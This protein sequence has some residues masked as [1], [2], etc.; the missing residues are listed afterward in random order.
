[1]KKGILLLSLLLILF[2][3]CTHRSSYESSTIDSYDSV[4]MDFTFGDELIGFEM[5]T[6]DGQNLESISIDS[7]NKLI[8]YLSDRCSPCIEALKSLNRLGNVFLSDDFDY[9]ICW[10][11]AIPTNLLEKYEIEKSKNFSLRGKTRLNSIVPT[12]FLLNED[13]IVRFSTN[14]FEI[15]IEKLFSDEVLEKKQLQENA[16]MYI[17]DKLVNLNKKSNLIFFSTEECQA[18]IEA[19]HIISSESIQ[20]SYD[21]T[22]I[23]GDKDPKDG[24]LLDDYNIFRHVYDMKW[25]PS[26]LIL[27]D[28]ED[29]SF[30]DGVPIEE[31]EDLLVVP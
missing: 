12:F 20:N 3:S 19:E 11:N 16:N 24:R 4:L 18:C 17:L 31:I 26:F 9:L 10:E 6:I 5:E 30:L 27:N 28:I 14:N 15:M 25:Y 7:K 13:N 2:T 21:V 1:M 22:T 29:Y 8:V 23:Y